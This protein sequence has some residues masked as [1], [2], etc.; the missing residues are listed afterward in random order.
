MAQ[1]FFK[2]L[3]MAKHI[4]EELPMA[5][6]V[7]RELPMAKLFFKE[8]P[9]AKLQLQRHCMVNVHHMIG[10]KQGA[11]YQDQLDLAIFDEK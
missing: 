3:P 7:L 5:N 9:L 4:L 2:E 6:L 10:E 1:L 11:T 8:L